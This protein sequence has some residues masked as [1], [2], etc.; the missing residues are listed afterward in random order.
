MLKM[1]AYRF[2]LNQPD[3]ATEALLR[4]HV[5]ANRWIWNEMMA[6]RE[7][8]RAEGSKMF[9]FFAACRVLTVLRESEEYAWLAA[10]SRDSLSRTLRANYLA[11]QRFFKRQSA[12]PRFKK[13][14]QN[15]CFGWSG[16]KI[17]CLDQANSRIRVPKMGWLR[18]RNSRHVAG[19]VKN[20][21]ISRKGG[22]WYI[23]IQTER[24][25]SAPAP[26]SHR[27]RVGIDMGIA[28]HT[29]LSDG[30]MAKGPNALKQAASRLARAQR[31]LAR[32]Q[33][34]SNRRRRQVAKIAKIHERVAHVR[35]DHLHKLT[36]YLSK[37]HGLI[38]I[39]DLRVRA[40]SASARGTKEA[41]GVN[42]RQKSGL[43]RSILDQGWGEMRRQLQYKQDWSGGTLVAV[44]PR[45]TSRMCSG[46]RHTHAANRPSQ[47][48]FRCQA[49]GVGLNADTNAA[50]NILAAGLAVTGRGGLANGRPA[51]RQPT[52]P[53][54]AA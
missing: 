47:A 25:V 52:E 39:E 27:Q 21:T 34:G 46:C 10:A 15:E 23:S 36:C 42:V 43:N 53:P 38:A 41:P 5:G 40:M 20:V 6:C 22:H 28:C 49:C 33:K 24:E 12:R 30:R 51:K 37:N 11:W 35:N 13:R 32:Q 48:V 8:L 19:V 2:R 16:I 45:N 4:Q 18:Y 9:G 1:Q 29:A 44:P 3:S 50:K 26:R 54:R 17:C 14:G 7:Q 31:Q